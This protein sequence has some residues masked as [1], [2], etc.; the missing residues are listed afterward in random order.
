MDSPRLVAD[1]IWML[2]NILVNV[3]FVGSTTW[4]D[5]R[6]RRAAAESDL[7][8]RRAAFELFGAMPPRAI[9]LTHGHFDHVGAL[10]GL[11][12]AWDVPVYA[13]SV[14]AAVTSPAGCRIRRPIRPSAAGSW[15]GRPSLFRDGP[16]RLRLAAAGRC[17]PTAACPSR[18][19]GS[20]SHTPGHTRDTSRCSDQADGVVDRR[21]RGH[22]HASRNR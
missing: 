10:P 5:S 7:G 2:R 9:V 21:R 3:F 11:L 12:E 19:T 8:I 14:R 20:R 17:R 1:G 22:H 18:Q 6:R 16:Q 4:L 13:H 15:R